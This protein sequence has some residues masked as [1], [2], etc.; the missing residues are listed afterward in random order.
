MRQLLHDSNP[1]VVEQGLVILRNLCMGDRHHIAAAL[2]WAGS[3]PAA[4]GTAGGAG[5]QGAATTTATPGTVFCP[6]ISPVSH[7]V[8]SQEH[9]FVQLPL[10]FPQNGGQESDESL[11]DVLQERILAGVGATSGTGQAASVAMD[12]WYR[13]RG[14]GGYDSLKVDKDSSECTLLYD[15]MFVRSGCAVA[16][17]SIILYAIADI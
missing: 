6:P 10:Q 11:L 1:R 15:G 13:H 4:A 14:V 3:A 16:R 7:H 8:G 5:P 2:E 12:R 17:Q 9:A